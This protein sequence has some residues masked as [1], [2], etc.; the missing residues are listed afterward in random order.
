MAGAGVNKCREVTAIYAQDAR[1]GRQ[2]E[3]AFQLEWYSWA[4]GLMTAMN[5]TRA[6]NGTK[7]KDLKAVPMEV[8][9]ETLLQFCWQNPDKE[10]T[11][12]IPPMFND[13]PDA[14]DQ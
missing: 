9:Q 1:N 6:V 10:Y 7:M 13:F 12:G 8:Q 2:G 3:L 11:E 4:Q 5:L 14:D